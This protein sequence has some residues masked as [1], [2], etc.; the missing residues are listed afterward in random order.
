MIPL[1]RAVVGYDAATQTYTAWHIT[2]TIPEMMGRTGLRLSGPAPDA[3]V[4]SSARAIVVKPPTKNAPKKVP[5]EPILRP[6]MP[7]PAI[8][9][10]QF[11]EIRS[12]LDYCGACPTGEPS[13]IP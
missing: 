1:R 11:L 2:T 3:P 7:I 9:A 10:S 6:Y 5:Q 12:Q 4:P 13:G 8:P